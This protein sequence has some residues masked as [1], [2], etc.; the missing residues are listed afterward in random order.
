MNATKIAIK[1]E[2][3]FN[4]VFANFY[5]ITNDFRSL[6][7]SNV[8][9]NG[10]YVTV[11]NKINPEKQRWDGALVIHFLNPPTSQEVVELIHAAN[12]PNDFGMEDNKTLWIWWD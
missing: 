2:K 11:S 6:I 12:H 3:E 10:G 5:M 9:A 8:I 7:C 1:S 4:N